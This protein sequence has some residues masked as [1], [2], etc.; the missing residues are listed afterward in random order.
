MQA[1]LSQTETVVLALAGLPS[2]LAIAED[3]RR[4]RISNL[5]WL[6]LA[7]L[8]GVRLWLV[9]APP[10]AHAL[11]ATALVALLLLAWLRGLLGGGD[12]KLLAASF[13]LFVGELPAYLLVLSLL[14]AGQALVWWPWARG[15]R[16]VRRLPLGLAIGA[17][18]LAVVLLLI[19]LAP[20]GGGA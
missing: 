15:G 6:A 12:V 18:N 9:G 8:G 13:L 17:A 20:A 5:F 3:L 16:K 2:L 11:V 19:F 10:L 4:R 14:V 7:L 1:E